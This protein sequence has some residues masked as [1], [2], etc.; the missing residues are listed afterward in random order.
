[1]K[2]KMFFMMLALTGILVLV[3]SFGGYYVVNQQL[4]VLTAD[5][6]RST[7]FMVAGATALFLCITLSFACLIVIH[8]MTRPIKKLSESTEQI[9]SGQLA[10]KAYDNGM[11]GK[12]GRHINKI[13]KNL[14]TI[15]CEINKISERNKS[16]ADTLHQSVL[17]T[18]KASNEIAHAITDVASNT[19][20]QAKAILQAKS[21]TDI[22]AGNSVEIAKKAT[23]TKKIAKQMVEVIQNSGV[24]FNKLTEKLKNTAEVSVGIADHVE[25]LYNEADKIKNIVTTVTEISERTNLLAL[26]AAIEAARAGEHGKGF[27]VV[28]DEVRKLAEQSA[29]ASEEIKHLIE[30]IIKSVHDITNKTKEEVVRINEDIQFADQSKHAFEDVAQTTQNTYDSIQHIFVLAEQSASVVKN[31][32]SLMDEVAASV[33]ETVA[34]TEEVSASAEEQSAAMQETAELI[35]NMRDMANHIDAKLYEFISKIKVTDKQQA[36]V[37]EGFKA[38]EKIA[39]HVRSNNLSMQST[40]AY[41]REQQKK[42]KQFEFA[43]IFNDKG[44]LIT[45][46][47]MS[48]VDDTDYSYR[49]YYIEAIKGAQ[50]KSQPYISTY[51]YNY[52]I[53]ISIPY[54]DG[55]NRI[56]G[57]A[58]ADICIED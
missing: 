43:G 37:K 42:Y 3:A 54:K 55:A 11:T 21:N 19:G 36:M 45:A 18:D 46:T 34:F 16:L 8:F 48:V 32:N 20:N 28:S 52:C 30:N 38:L 47:D 6:F 2:T 53:S 51:S 14:K 15:L 25:A 13:V 56:I 58:V 22:M 17:H 1:M 10:I 41:L 35:G 39:E 29:L 7:Y 26:N 40:S 9:S 4:H 49:P 33:E 57:V 44:R 27:A 5:S 24:V 31:V 12:V 23:D 50:F